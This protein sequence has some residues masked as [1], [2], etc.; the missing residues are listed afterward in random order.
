MRT[1]PEEIILELR[2]T[3]SRLEKEKI[4]SKAMIEQLDEFFEGIQ[5]CLNPLITF[6]I[7]QVPEKKVDSGQGL[8][9]I[10]F[11]KLLDQLVKRELTG[12]AARDAISLSMDVATQS[13]WNNFYRL[14]LI[15]DLK[16]GVSE[17]TINSVAKKI[18]KKYSIPIFQCQL[19][20]D[21]ANHE[22][23]IKGKKI[24]Q[25]KLD[26][27]RCLAVIKQNSVSLYSRNGKLFNN[28]QKIEEELSIIPN[29]HGE[30]VIDGEIMSDTFQNLMKQV[31]R[32]T[33]VNA[34]DSIFH[35]FDI[36]SLQDFIE[37]KNSINQ[38]DRLNQLR[39]ICEKHSKVFNHIKFLDYTL[40]DLDSLQGKSRFNEINQD[41]IKNGYEGLMI[42]DIDSFYTFKRSH[43]W[44]KIKPFIEVT[45]T[46]IDIERGT[47]R[48]IN[49][50]GALQCSGI[51]DGKQIEVSVGSGFS[52]SQRDEFW[53]NK[54]S[55]IGQLVEIRADAITQNQ[56]TT[57][58][59][60]R[61]PRFKTFRSYMNDQ[62]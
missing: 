12:N 33:D 31:H 61:F 47:G 43:D 13:Q 27:V 52:D 51:D 40:L 53:K 5:Y 26:G 21:G 36:V 19:A 39:S 11:K 62:I 42:K 18:N 30:V 59:S 56:D 20:H 35:V 3:N 25:T 60:L 17:K 1:Q 8:N 6:G 41:A 34:D 50:L 37:Q 29:T 48:N 4:L 55:I 24:V 23:K 54:S 22:S 45:L 2:Q 46:V 7:K 16:S 28:F 58:Y 10:S 49:R 32:K 44:L 57:T 15:K 9:W 14:I 38:I